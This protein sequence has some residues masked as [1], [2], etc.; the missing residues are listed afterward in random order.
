MQ[1]NDLWLI[2]RVEV[3]CDSFPNFLSKIIK[4]ISFGKDRFAKC[5]SCKSAIDRVFNQEYYFVHF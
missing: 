1:A 3:T 4:I 2:V 5:A